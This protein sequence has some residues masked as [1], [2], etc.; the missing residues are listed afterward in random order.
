MCASR[1]APKCS[2]CKCARTQ[3]CNPSSLLCR[4]LVADGYNARIAGVEVFNSDSFERV[5]PRCR[6]SNSARTWKTQMAETMEIIHA[7]A[8]RPAPPPR[9][10]ARR[11]EIVRAAE[12]HVAAR[13][14]PE[15]VV[16]RVSETR[17]QY[18]RTY[19]TELY[20][21][22]AVP[23]RKGQPVPP[24]A[25]T[26]TPADELG[27]HADP[28]VYRRTHYAT[29]PPMT[30]FTARGPE[31]LFSGGASMTK[32][33][34]T[35]ALESTGVIPATTVHAGPGQRI[36]V[37]G[38]EL[39][40]QLLF[41]KFVRRLREAGST[42]EDFLSHLAQHVVPPEDEYGQ[43]VEA[44]EGHA[45]SQPGVPSTAFRHACYALRLAVTDASVQSII[46]ACDTGRSD[47][48]AL[49]ALTHFM[50]N[51]GNA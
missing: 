21:L 15:E 43:G 5:M 41:T 9:D 7:P 24:E 20:V 50:T 46:V 19:P 32:L 11:D 6:A 40:L 18:G 48:L 31:G 3:R 51:V 44:V 33:A 28:D 2:Q 27:I 17:R 45:A 10:L 25:R 14:R 4:V 16:D 42:P 39:A 37:P 26:L 29:C 13:S 22:G 36:P 34:A 8:T 12:A 35:A 49:S 47:R 23:K 38:A 1:V 30:F